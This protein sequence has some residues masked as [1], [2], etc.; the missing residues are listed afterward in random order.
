VRFVCGQGEPL[1]TSDA[2]QTAEKTM[3]LWER[4]VCEIFIAPERAEPEHYFEF[5]VAPTG[6]WIDLE[7]RW[8]PEARETDWQYC[9]GMEAAAK[10]EKE[11]II[12]A[13]RVP[14]EAF[15]REMPRAGDLW[16][17]NLFRCVGKGQDRGYLA[18]QPTHTP[19]PNFHLPQAFGWLRFDE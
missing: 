11:R 17:A 14:L 8:R 9:S 4:D 5:E 16:R 18:W 12:V 19:Q 2:P 10:I 1:V 6:E 3:G 15:R 7:L 13:M